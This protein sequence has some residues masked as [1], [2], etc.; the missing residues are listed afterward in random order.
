MNQLV[1]LY[2]QRQRNFNALEALEPFGRLP[3]EMEFPTPAFPDMLWLEAE[4]PATSS[5]QMTDLQ[6]NV[7]DCVSENHLR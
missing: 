6:K 1:A 4:A 5:Q 3:K 7:V 2:I